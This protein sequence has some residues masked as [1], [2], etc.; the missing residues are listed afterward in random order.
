MYIT[1][2]HSLSSVSGIILIVTYSGNKAHI[3]LKKL[4]ILFSG[5]TL[6]LGKHGSCTNVFKKSVFFSPRGRHL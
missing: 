3:I 1:L 6:F 2:F 5:Q 4:L